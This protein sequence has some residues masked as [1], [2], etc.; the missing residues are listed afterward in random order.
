ML[1]AWA[2]VANNHRLG[3]LKQE[4]ASSRGFGGPTSGIKVL[5]EAMLPAEALGEEPV[6]NFWWLQ[7][8]LG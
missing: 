2:A 8:A 6:L 1:G 3:G 7:V 4:N 5:T